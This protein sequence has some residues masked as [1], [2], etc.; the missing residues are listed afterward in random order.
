MAGLDQ[1]TCWQYLILLLLDSQ[2]KLVSD[3]WIYFNYLFRC[4]I[5]KY[6]FCSHSLEF[7]SY[8][9][10]SFQVKG[11]GH[12]LTLTCST[13]FKRIHEWWLSALQQAYRLGSWRSGTWSD[14]FLFYC[15]ATSRF[16]VCMMTTPK[17]NNQ[18]KQRYYSSWVLVIP[19]QS[20][21][22]WPQCNGSRRR[23]P[24]KAPLFLHFLTG[25]YQLCPFLISQN[26]LERKHKSVTS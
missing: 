17:G 21:G 24:F 22:Y 18:M 8:W 20:M 3:H 26:L 14:F 10:P 11:W 16:S 1:G 12:G 2:A 15:F 4:Y 5:F 6:S 25:Q 7:N 9:W 19:S 23:A 13:I